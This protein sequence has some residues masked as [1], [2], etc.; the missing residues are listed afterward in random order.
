MK[1]SWKERIEPMLVN[2]VLGFGAWELDPFDGSIAFD[3]TAWL[4]FGVQP[5][6]E[7]ESESESD[8]LAPMVML[9]GPHQIL[10]LKTHW[11]KVT[12]SDSIFRLK[13]ASAG[14]AARFFSMRGGL[15]DGK[16]S[17]LIWD[18]TLENQKVTLA[19]EGSGFGVWK[20]HPKT[21]ALTWDDKMYAIYGHTRETFDEQPST[22]TSTLHEEDRPI[23]AKRFAEL[24][25]GQPVEIFEF[26]II[27]HF[28]K[29]IRYIEG[30]GSALTDPSGKV[31]LVVG[32]NRDITDRKMELERLEQHRVML[33]STSKMAELGAMAAG[34]A[35]EINNPLAI[36][37]GKTE[38]LK[39]KI[40]SNSL[41]LASLEADLDLLFTVSNRIG[42]IVRSLRTYSRNA[43]GD[44]KINVRIE[45]IFRDTLRLCVDRFKSSKIEV[46]LKLGESEKVLILCRPTQISQVFLNLL[47][48]SADALEGQDEK[49]ITIRS[50]LN[51][52]WL[53]V[54]FEDSG[55]GV[56]PEVAAKIFD[57][58]YTTKQPG[59]GTGLGLS[60][61][62]SIIEAHGGRIALVNAPRDTGHGTRGARFRIELPVSDLN[63]QSQRPSPELRAEEKV[64]GETE[65]ATKVLAGNRIL[66]VDDEKEIRKILCEELRGRGATAVG[67]GSSDEALSMILNEKFDVLI[68]DFAMPGGDGL[69]LI[70]KVNEQAAASRPIVFLCTAFNVCTEEMARELRISAIFAKPFRINSICHIISE[71]L[72]K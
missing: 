1:F 22:W 9:F 46:D 33:A 54:I 67:A 71:K 24:L 49:K 63:F 56:S 72:K 20:F 17:G 70:R 5:E 41:D 2:P 51:E 43:D 65:V 27:R 47:S 38:L 8:F 53:Q 25:N 58:F 36:L 16:V 30:N 55:T 14:K 64:F 34:I 7:S 12:V 13:S 44:P 35:H 69:S 10:S 57:P 61:S 45:E 50:L 28:D 32:M 60:I 66:V 26:R 52:N 6:S 15:R 19:L 4:A 37:V 42:E 18:S 11:S 29:S 62:K 31:L 59:K 48:N 39:R 68:T 21:S 40:D 23:V 3:S